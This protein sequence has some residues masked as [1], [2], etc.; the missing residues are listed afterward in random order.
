MLSKMGSQCGGAG[1]YVPETISF[2]LSLFFFLRFIYLF[3]GW[4]GQL[5]LHSGFL[6]PRLAGAIL[7][8]WVQAS[9]CSGFSCC[10]AQALGVQASVV[11]AH[12]L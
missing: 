9:Q 8:C 2:S 6:W 4:W 11:A 3:L 1:V 10:G 7:R 12:L 5:L